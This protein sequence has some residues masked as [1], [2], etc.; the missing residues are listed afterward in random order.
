MFKNIYLLGFYIGQN[1][2]EHP[3]LGQ[4]TLDG[5]YS[6]GVFARRNTTGIRED[7][8]CEMFEFSEVKLLLKPTSDS[9]LKRFSDSLR[10][11][12]KMASEGKW[13]GEQELFGTQI[14]KVKL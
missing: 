14:T 1:C 5:F 4:Y 9:L 6:K 2:I 7:E 13:I 11:I 12:K 8:E 3:K 10:F